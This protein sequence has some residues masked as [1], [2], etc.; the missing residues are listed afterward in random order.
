MAEGQTSPS[1]AETRPNLGPGRTS[2]TAGEREARKRSAHKH[3]ENGNEDTTYCNL[4]R[5]SAS[6]DLETAFK[7]IKISSTVKPELCSDC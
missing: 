2:H 1:G 5:R 3:T 4:L 6:L 7:R